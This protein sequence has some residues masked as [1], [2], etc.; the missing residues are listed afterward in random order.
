VTAAA[1]ALAGG[2]CEL[3]GAVDAGVDGDGD[4]VEPQALAS[5]MLAIAN[6]M[7]LLRIDELL[8]VS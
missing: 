1:G 4:A 2:G 6:P 3:P 7:N 8:H 5:T